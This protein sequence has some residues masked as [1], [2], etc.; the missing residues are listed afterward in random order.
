M[1]SLLHPFTSVGGLIKK[2]TTINPELS[3]PELIALIRQATRTQGGTSNEYASSEVVDEEF[4]LELARA[5]L[6]PFKG[7]KANQ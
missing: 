6:T 3:V 4:A 1:S 2:I 7:N 5:T